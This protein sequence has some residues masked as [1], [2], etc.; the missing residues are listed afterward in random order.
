MVKADAY[1]HGAS[2]LLPELEK[3]DA[4]CGY[5]VATLSEAILLRAPGR[6][7]KEVIVFSDS[8]V[9]NEERAQAFA[10]YQLTPV[11]SSMQALLAYSECR[12]KIPFEVEVTTGMNRSGIRVEDLTHLKVRPKGIFTHLA[13]SDLPDSRLS[14]LQ[15]R[16]IRRLL[17]LRN[18]RFQNAR[19]H[20]GNSGAILCAA[21]WGLKDSDL[22]RPGISLYGIAPSASGNGALGR[23]LRPVMQFEAQ[24]LQCE[25]I[26]FGERVGYGGLHRV[27]KKRGEWVLTLGAGYADGVPRL[28]SERG[29][30]RL[31]RKRFPIIGRVS[32]DVTN[33][34]ASGPVAAGTF[35]EI[36]G[37]HRPIWGAALQVDSIPYELL[38]GVSGRVQRIYE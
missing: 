8:G 9:W 10:R 16:G 33:A 32:M 29:E 4:V 3:N 27:K 18:E 19:I 28:L 15:L 20:W 1:G 17:D 34:E 36:W 5:G 23:E 12:T 30:L 7:K 11:L 35:L 25:K 38:T 6:S 14:Q 37:P 26:P 13:E 22:V 24:V 2:Q 21:G 31:G